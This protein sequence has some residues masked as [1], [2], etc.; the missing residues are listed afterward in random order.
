MS[1]RLRERKDGGRAYE[2]RL[3]HCGKA[4]QMTWAVPP[5]YS[6]RKAEAEAK[7]IEADF[8]ASIRRGEVLTKQEQKAKE[9][10]EAAIEEERRLDEKSKVTVE[11]YC[12][13]FLK[14][15][16]ADGLQ[17]N[18]LA[19]YR[20]VL[21]RISKEIGF[22]KLEDVTRG[23]L[24]TLLNDLEASGMKHST[25]KC[26]RNALKSLFG[27]AEDDGL[28]DESPAVFKRGYLP[29]DRRYTKV[30]P[31]TF[32]DKEAAEIFKCLL[33]NEPYRVYALIAFM[34]E[35]GCRRGEVAALKWENV[36]LENKKVV[37]KANLQYA[38][39]CGTYVTSPKNGKERT[40]FISDNCVNILQQLHVEQLKRNMRYGVAPSGYVFEGKPG[41]N[42]QPSSIT[43]VFKIL[44]DRYGFK[45][46]H[47]H[48]LRHTC[49]SLSIL[50]G[51]DPVTVQT[52]LG[53]SSVDITL[54][55]Y[56]HSH[57]AALRKASETLASAI[58]QKRA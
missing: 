52:K 48:K 30:E 19:N 39:T 29:K 23:M 43:H 38:K 12:T 32:T 1:R 49:A 9:A 51:V 26:Y 20:S 31:E 33:E 53:H 3:T 50:H 6:A 13:I 57:E 16:E 10:A 15:R 54:N 37:I 2:I 44:G 25:C 22:V 35:T 14:K 40:V 36:D 56:S 27:Q 18:S 7:K 41:R 24:T 8:I 47:P 28:I 42:F 4:Y 58:E 17:P 34:T 46:F 55:V 11:E 5:S 21:G 45:D